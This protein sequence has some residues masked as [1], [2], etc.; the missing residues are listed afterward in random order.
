MNSSIDFNHDHSVCQKRKA[1]NDCFLSTARNRF[2]SILKEWKLGPERAELYD[3]ILHI[4]ETILQENRPDVVKESVDSPKSNHTLPLYCQNILALNEFYQLQFFKITYFLECLEKSKLSS[5]HLHRIQLFLETKLFSHL[6]IEEFFNQMTSLDNLYECRK[7]KVYAPLH[8]N[9]ADISETFYLSVAHLCKECHR[10]EM[11]E[12]YK[13][14]GLKNVDSKNL[15]LKPMAKMYLCMKCGEDNIINFYERNKSKCKYCILQ[16]KRI[17]ILAGGEA[18]VAPSASKTHSCRVCH[19]EDPSQFRETYKSLC[20]ACFLVEKKEKYKQNL[21]S[22]G[23]EP[24]APRVPYFC[25]SCETAD[26]SKFRRGYKSRCYE[27]FLQ[28]KNWK[29]N[30]EA[31]SED[32]NLESSERLERSFK[33][34]IPQPRKVLCKYCGDKN[35]RNFTDGMETVCTRCEELDNQVFYCVKCTMEMH[36]SCFTVLRN[37]SSLDQRSEVSTENLTCDACAGV[38]VFETKHNKKRQ[39]ENCDETR[40]E[41]FYAGFKGKCK[42]CVREYRRKNYEVRERMWKK[43]H[44]LECGTEEAMDFYPHHKSKCKKCM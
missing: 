22:E 1:E 25:E 2:G 28:D 19:T 41:E 31:K 26:P 36:R 3:T 23:I 13:A 38:E 11:R 20:Y 29:R 27:C 21:G 44:C 7:C 10:N 30:A 43:Y 40:P 8:A 9:I 42:K 15:A 14:K 16:E 6:S 32:T 37:A 33:I 4:I 12:I 5:V 39:C 18:I 35:Y 17:Q 34:S 24:K